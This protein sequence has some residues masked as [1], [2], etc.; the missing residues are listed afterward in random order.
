MASVQF[1]T[2]M[3]TKVSLSKVLTLA[4]LLIGL[5]ICVIP[6]AVGFFLDELK[7]D[8]FFWSRFEFSS[9]FYKAAKLDVQ[10]FPQSVV[11]WSFEKGNS[12]VFSDVKLLVQGQTVQKLGGDDNTFFGFRDVDGDGTNEFLFTSR[13]NFGSGRT[14]CKWFGNTWHKV[15]VDRSSARI[16]QMAEL[17]FYGTM[18]V[19]LGVTIVFL[20]VLSMCWRAMMKRIRSGNR[21]KMPR[22]SVI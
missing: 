13:S 2:I 14:V 12:G 18:V 3:N 19:G 6:F 10:G 16:F 9:A 17:M 21:L 4:L 11:E 15:P 22:H 8:P 7:L 5:I 20:G 1:D